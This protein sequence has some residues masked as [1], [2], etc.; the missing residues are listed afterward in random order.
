MAKTIKANEVAV[1]ANEVAVEANEVAVETNEVAVELT[2]TEAVV[3]A[4]RASAEAVGRAYGADRA[5]AVAL[6]NL[7]APKWYDETAD[8]I[9]DLGKVVKAEKKEYF[10]ALKAYAPKH[11]NPSNNWRNIR[12]YGKQEAEGEPEKGEG[13]GEGGEGEGEGEGGNGIAPLQDR[14][15]GFLHSAYKAYH[16]DETP[17]Q[18]CRNSIGDIKNALL[19]LGMDVDADPDAPKVFEELEQAVKEALAAEGESETPD[20]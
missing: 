15:I 8:S 18:A 19:S 11:S 2:P 1:E 13:E 20:F 17:N 14:L 12:K 5:Y 4:R 16:R 3:L 6:N 9:T 7:L 10:K